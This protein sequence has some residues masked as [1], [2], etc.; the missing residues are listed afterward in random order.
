M[1][2]TDEIQIRATLPNGEVW[3]LNY[4]WAARLL[5]EAK[6]PDEGEEHF[7]E[8][9]YYLENPQEAARDLPSIVAWDD[10]ESV[11]ERIEGADETNY[12]EQW[13]GAGLDVIGDE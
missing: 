7:Q 11:A 10:I 3:Q 6:Y 13:M 12:R 4:A 1:S 5:S 2:W 8:R 9:R